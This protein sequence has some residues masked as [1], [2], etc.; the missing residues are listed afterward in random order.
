[1]LFDGNHRRAFDLLHYSR[2]PEVRLC[3]DLTGTF[4]NFFTALDPRKVAFYLCAHG[5]HEWSARVRELV[6]ESM[7]GAA[8][9]VEQ[10]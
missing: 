8:I 7:A 9:E 6:C 5:S 1:M 3:V 10:W 4:E 2:L